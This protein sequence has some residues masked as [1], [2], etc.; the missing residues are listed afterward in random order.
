MN[1][2]PLQNPFY[3]MSYGMEYPFGQRKS[4]VPTLPSQLLGPFAM[5]GLGSVQHCSAV[6]VN[7][8]VLSILLI[9]HSIIPDIL[10]KTVLSQL[11][12]RYLLK[13]T[14]LSYSLHLFGLGHLTMSQVS[15][16]SVTYL[17]IRKADRSLADKVW[18]PIL[19]SLKIAQF[20][21]AAFFNT[22]CGTGGVN[23]NVLNYK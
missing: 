17:R 4:A 13:F 20:I 22:L 15:K 7:I 9:K 18:F 14:T 2:H 12:L 1:S 6:I 19:I 3:V 10:K 23:E 8:T 11:N 16:R 5:N 21:Q